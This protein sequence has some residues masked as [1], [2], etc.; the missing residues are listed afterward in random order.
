MESM[1]GNLRITRKILI[2]K[3]PYSVM[4]RTSRVYHPFVTT[5][6]KVRIKAMFFCLGHN[7]FNLLPFMKKGTVANVISVD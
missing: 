4:E 6:P 1:R 7:L 2:S 3:R 5:V